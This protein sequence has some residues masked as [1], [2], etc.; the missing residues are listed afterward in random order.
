M[1]N[2]NWVCP[3]C[4]RHVTL[5]PSQ[6]SANRHTVSIPNSEGRQTLLTE[7]LVC[8]NGECGKI[9]LLAEL[10]SS[11]G[12]A[13]R[14][15]LDN[16]LRKWQLLP[17]TKARPFPE[18]V[19]RRLRANYEEACAIAELSPRASAMLA[20][21]CLKGM[22]RDFWAVSAPSGKLA[23]ELDAIHDRL[24]ADTWEAIDSVRR[25]APIGAHMDTSAIGFIDIDAQAAQLLVGLIET[26]FI[27]WYV[28]RENRKSRMAAVVATAQAKEP[29]RSLGVVLR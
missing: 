1:S 13:H 27:E 16:F 29:A 10:H 26:L 21:D 28:T 9:T 4:E 23:D 20:L 24:D 15:V 11:H 17:L 3:H 8:P 2:M 5:A 25:I 12:I 6:R 7:F 18:C 14:E 22:I 19:P